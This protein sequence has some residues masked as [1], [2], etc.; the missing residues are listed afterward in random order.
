MR[1]T[2]AKLQGI[3]YSSEIITLG[4]HYLPFQWQQTLWKVKKNKISMQCIVTI[5]SSF[6]I[7]YPF[8]LHLSIHKTFCFVAETARTK[9]S[10][11][12]LS[13]ICHWLFVKSLAN[14]FYLSSRCIFKIHFCCPKVHSAIQCWKGVFFCP[15][16]AK[17]K[18][19]LLEL[20]PSWDQGG[21][22]LLISGLV[23]APIWIKAN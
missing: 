10:L 9:T 18:I 5:G 1:L 15:C 16:E 13:A 14:C 21:V 6:L 12:Y 3:S 19:L 17:L 7:Y 20:N 4:L 11:F 22:A 8:F 2:C 23:L